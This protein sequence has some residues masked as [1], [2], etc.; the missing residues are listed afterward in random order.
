M[1]RTLQLQASTAAEQTEGR[2]GRKKFFSET[3]SPYGKPSLH[4]KVTIREGY[5]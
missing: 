5:A 1:K 4:K 2:L 3:S